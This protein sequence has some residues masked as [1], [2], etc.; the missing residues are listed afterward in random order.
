[1]SDRVCFILSAVSLRTA[2]LLLAL[3]QCLVLCLLQPPDYSYCL[4]HADIAISVHDRRVRFP[5]PART[6]PASSAHVGCCSLLCL[7]VSP[8]IPWHSSR[9][10]C[11]SASTQSPL[12]HWPTAC[13]R[14]A[15]EA[16][17]NKTT[18]YAYPRPGT[19][20]V[21]MRGKPACIFSSCVH[22]SPHLVVR[23]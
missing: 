12:P 8:G 2:F 4:H 10:A 11:V 7:D 14:R 13:H 19:C 1:V 16:Q 20:S 6:A 9:D 18:A 21:Q 15:C 22:P 3:T 23:L 17:P 5:A